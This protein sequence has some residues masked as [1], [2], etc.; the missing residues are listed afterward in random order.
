VLIGAACFELT[1]PGARAPQDAPRGERY[2]PWRGGGAWRSGAQTAIFSYRYLEREY[3]MEVERWDGGWRVTAPDGSHQLTVQ[4]GPT[5]RVTALEGT[6]VLSFGAARVGEDLFV[7]WEGGL[8]ELGPPRRDTAGAAPARHASPGEGLTAP[9]P[10]TVIK[11][12]VTEGE[13]VSA[14]QPLVVLEAMKMEHV[15]EAPH[16]GVVEEIMVQEGELV[17]G[18]APVVRLG[19]A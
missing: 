12:A 19:P 4:P 16:E 5:G 10:G 13:A 7:E 17:A 11:I 2:N 14:H 9:M 18:G 3:T 15:V 1:N 8:Y 6:R